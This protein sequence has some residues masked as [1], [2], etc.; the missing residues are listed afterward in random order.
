MY[1]HMWMHAA[2]RDKFPQIAAY[3]QRTWLYQ[4]IIIQINVLYECKIRS[5]FYA[6]FC[7]FIHLCF[8]RIPDK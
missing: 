2:T 8:D 4:L 5:M 7:Y 3:I 6:L 1:T